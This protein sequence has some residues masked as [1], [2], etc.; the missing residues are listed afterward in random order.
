MVLLAVM[1][2]E[3]TNNRKK[4][5]FQFKKNIF[6]FFK[7]DFPHTHNV[8]IQFPL[9]VLLPVPSHFPS[10]SDVLPFYLSLENRLLRDNNKI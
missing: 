6:F 2:L 9:P 1:I 3:V 5:V 10:H 7:M 4:K 8:S